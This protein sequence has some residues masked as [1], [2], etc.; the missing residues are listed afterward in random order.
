MDEFRVVALIDMDSFYAQVEE[1]ERPECR[2]KPLAVVQ[3]TANGQSGQA[4]AVNYAARA[5]G[6]QRGMGTAEMRRICPIIH[7]CRVPPIDGLQEKGDLGKYRSASEEV[8]EVLAGFSQNIIVEKA[9]IDEAYLDLT[10]SCKNELAN[11]TTEDFVRKM[12]SETDKLFPGTFLEMA[13]PML[14]SGPKSA[15]H[16][17]RGHTGG[18]NPS[19]NLGTN[20]FH[21][22]SRNCTQQ[23]IV[24]AKNLAKKVHVVK[25]LAKL[26]CSRH[27]PSRQSVIVPQNIA[28][29]FEDTPI[30]SVRS[31]GGK[32]G[33]QLMQQF[34]VKTMGDL[35]LVP[36][37]ELFDH[38]PES[39]VWLIRLLDG[40]D[41]DVVS[42]KLP[43]KS[44]GVSKNFP[45]QTALNSTASAKKWVQG[46]SVELSKRLIEHESKHCG[47]L[48]NFERY[49]HISNIHFSASRFEATER[50][51]KKITEFFQGPQKKEEGGNV[52]DA[53]DKEDSDDILF[54]DKEV[55]SE[56]LHSPRELSEAKKDEAQVEDD[57][58]VTST[59]E[60]VHDEIVVITLSDDSTDA[61]DLPAEQRKK[62]E[63]RKEE[64]RKLKNV[65]RRNNTEEKGKKRSVEKNVV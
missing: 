40:E 19:S 47:G 65:Q 1:R 45:G 53:Y 61:S 52:E 2:G 35:Q 42:A 22:F 51:V 23:G 48:H 41:D 6:V 14:S 4:I 15:G 36:H 59:T 16:C 11:E 37:K 30:S 32:F 44:V 21:L 34:S 8:F 58:A 12:V 46:L 33:H 43:P 62:G 28:Q 26:V 38:F 3:I 64:M 50:R 31:L 63:T 56:D 60:N 57:A 49:P 54:L 27:K 18:A 9:S 55:L 13:W 20:A 25:V 39:A 10:E 5:F 17:D 24:F 7:L 29:L